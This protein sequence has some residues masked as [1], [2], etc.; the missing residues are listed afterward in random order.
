MT[1]GKLFAG[2]MIAALTMFL[3]A[4]A[5]AQ[6]T[7]FCVPAF[8]TGCTNNGTNVAQTDLEAAMN[9]G[10]TAIDGTPDLIL[11]QP[12]AVLADTGTFELTG[13]TDDLLI[14]GGDVSTDLRT[15]ATDD[16]LIVDLN[17]G[18]EARDVSIEDLSIQIPAAMNDGEGAGIALSGDTLQNVDINSFNVGGVGVSDIVGGATITGGLIRGFSGGTI[19]VGIRAGSSVTADVDISGVRVL[20]AEFGISA[21]PTSGTVSVDRSRIESTTAGISATAG[22]VDVTNSIFESDGPLG[23]SASASGAANATVNA[24]G[25]TLVGS[26]SS[27][28]PFNANVNAAIAGSSTVNVENSIATGF[29][30]G[31]VRSSSGTGLANINIDRSNAKTFG[32]DI[33]PGTANVTNSEELAPLFTD[34]GNGD[35]SLTL[36]SPSIDAGDPTSTLTSD[37]NGDLRP[38]DGDSNGT[39]IVDQ[40]AF[41]FQTDTTPPNTVINSGPAAGSTITVDEATFGFSGTPVPDVAGFQC[42]LDGGAFLDC[43]S[44]KTFSNLSEGSHTVSI[45]AEDGFGNQDATPA[46][47]TFIVDAVAPPDTTAPETT[48]DSGPGKKAKKGKPKFEFSSSESGSTFECSVVKKGK[49]AK[50]ETC[51]PPQSYKL[52]RKKKATKYVFSVQATDGAGNTDSSPATKSFKVSKKKPKK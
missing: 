7:T 20:G 47:R 43:T 31:F 44:P 40:G 2:A 18:G 3:A 19:G 10:A 45:R 26:G 37:F 15:E 16:R 23:L 32:P 38:R 6:A 27:T 24:D 25:V 1:M 28:S 14:D 21:A 11:I 34:A 51:T 22:T 33:G 13:G 50:F 48:I 17:A 46:T 52:K 36:A 42:K 41:E 29:S 49:D 39:S 8:H 4:A 30:L 35:Y 9:P 12:G 5:T